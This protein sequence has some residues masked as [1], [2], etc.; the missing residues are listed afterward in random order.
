[1]ATSLMERPVL[2]RYLAC[3]MRILNLYRPM[4]APYRCL[5]TSCSTLRLI[6]ASLASAAVLMRVVGSSS[7][8]FLARLAAFRMSFLIYLF[9]LAMLQIFQFS[10]PVIGHCFLMQ[11]T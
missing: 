5:K 10:G 9:S 3:D 11:V 8:N 4:G 2:N 7:I 6:P 1:M